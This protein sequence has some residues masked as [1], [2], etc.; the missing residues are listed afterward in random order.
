MNKVLV[1]DVWNLD[2]NHHEDIEFV[3]VALNK[4]NLLFIDPC[5]INAWND[6]WAVR[7]NKTM[8]SFFN[9]FYQAY[10]D[11]DMLLK[12]SLLSHAREENATRLGYG[13]G[14][15]GKGNTAQGLLK[16]FRPLETLINEIDTIG[17][18]QDL[19]I[20]I[21]GFAEDGFSDLLTN[22]L[23]AELNEFTLRQMKKYNIQPNG[24]TDFY[25]WDTNIQNWVQVDSECYFYGKVEI[26]LVPKQIVRKNYLFGVGQYFERI[27]L[28]RVREDEDWY[29]DNNKPIP[30]RDIAKQLRTEEEHWQYDYAINYSRNHSDA[31]LEYHKRLKSYYIEFGQPIEDEVLDEL[32]LKFEVASA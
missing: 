15:N 1:T 11:N 14:D 21:P 26:L 16:D 13:R 6:E 10:R 5:M 2:K 17:I 30:K 12:H 4:D 22:I 23:H 24:T 28:E 31:L 9:K 8:H 32:L 19:T 7:A 25:T 3:N 20:F 29:T 27:I 18:P